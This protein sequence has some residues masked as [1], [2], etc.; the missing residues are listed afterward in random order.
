M[1]ISTASSF[2]RGVSMMQQLQQALDRTQQQISSGQRI[3][4]PSDDPIAA[5]RTIE[6]R[7]SLSRLE[8][9]ERNGEIARNR[10][11]YEETA[12]VSVND[13]LQRV[14]ELTVLANNDTQSPESRRLIAGELRERVDQLVHIANQRDGGGRFLFS[15]NRDGAAPVTT[16]GGVFTYNG[17]QGQRLIQIAEDRQIPDSDAGASVFF[18]IKDGNGAFSSSAAASNTGAGILTA[19][20][21]ADASQYDRDSYTVRFT[22]SDS[23]DVLDSTGSIVSSSAFTPGDTIAFRGIEFAITGVPASGDEFNI[24]PSRNRDMFSGILDL[25]TALEQPVTGDTSRAALHNGVNSALQNIDQAI[26]KVL[27]IRT[28]VGTRLNAIESQ[29]ENNASFE[30]T[31]QTTLAGIEDLDYAEALSLLSVQA[32]TLEAAQASFARTQSLSLFNYL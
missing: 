27:D 2:Q 12:L 3:L 26:G 11:S 31:L 28:Q 32:S 14:R 17:D 22:A 19:G 21:V 30:L 6:L 7:E 24:E 4:S 15:G 16:S 1:R 20:S 13:T 5:A 18:H 23:Y 10:L 25:A 9:F 29:V 8:Q